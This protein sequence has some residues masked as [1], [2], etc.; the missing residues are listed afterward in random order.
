MNIA[1]DTKDLFKME[2]IVSVI[3]GAAERIKGQKDK[4]DSALYH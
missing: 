1:W 3:I 2:T 4:G